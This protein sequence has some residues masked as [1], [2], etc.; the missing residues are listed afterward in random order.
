MDVMT[1]FVNLEIVTSVSTK[2]L[3]RRKMVGEFEVENDSE[4]VEVCIQDSKDGSDLIMFKVR[5]SDLMRVIS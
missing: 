5:V 3:F 2:Y 4:W 1:Q